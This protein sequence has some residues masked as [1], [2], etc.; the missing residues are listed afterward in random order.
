M[1]YILGSGITENPY[2]IP[3]ACLL[4]FACVLS[5]LACRVLEKSN[6]KKMFLVYIFALLSLVSVVASV[7]LLAKGSEELKESQTSKENERTNDY[8]PEVTDRSTLY[9]QPRG[10]LEMME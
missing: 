7:Y 6:K 5:L 1:A 4:L 10:K 2:V 9:H 3:S 8:V